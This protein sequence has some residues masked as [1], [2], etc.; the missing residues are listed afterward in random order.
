MAQAA[1]H[2]HYNAPGGISY[3]NAAPMRVMP[4]GLAETFPQKSSDRQ[5][6]YLVTSMHGAD[7]TARKS[8]TVTVKLTPLTG[9]PVFKYSNGCVQAWCNPAELKLLIWG[10]PGDLYSTGDRWWSDAA[11]PMVA[12][13][14]TFTVSLDPT[15]WTGVLGQSGATSAGYHNCLKQVLS[16]GMTFGGGYYAGHGLSTDGGTAEFE[17][18]KYE[19]D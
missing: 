18:L 8:I 15:H 10:P 2:Q 14:H 3:G 19:V 12:G 7:L 17:L 1:W 6:N 9:A 11:I 13:V 5:F 4:D 16:I